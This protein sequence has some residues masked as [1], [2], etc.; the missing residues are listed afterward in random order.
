M[1]TKEITWSLDKA[2]YKTNRNKKQ[3][4]KNK[5]MVDHKQSLF[6]VEKI[7]EQ[8]HFNSRLIRG[9]LLLLLPNK[10]KSRG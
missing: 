5:T 9:S 2:P 6:R 4:R 10:E 1:H 8:W 7:R 3:K